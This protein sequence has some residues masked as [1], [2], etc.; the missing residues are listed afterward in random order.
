[1]APAPL[2]RDVAACLMPA[3]LE[4]DDAEGERTRFCISRTAAIACISLEDGG[5]ASEVT[6][7]R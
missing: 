5:L 3:E 6:M 1:M 7:T 4:V 2:V